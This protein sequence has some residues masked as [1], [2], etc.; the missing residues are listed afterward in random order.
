MASRSLRR[1]ILEE[2]RFISPR[3]VKNNAHCQT[4]Q[5]IIREMVIWY[6]LLNIPHANL[7]GFYGFVTDI[8]EGIGLVSPLFSEGSI[9][10]YLGRNPLADRIAL[11]GF[12]SRHLFP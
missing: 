6:K 4:V 11:V 9:I 8:E 5:R 10:E 1:E 3:A 2:R 12:F 7:V